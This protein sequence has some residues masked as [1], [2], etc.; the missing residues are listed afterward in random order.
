MWKQ[1]I[2]M[3]E[4]IK[5][6]KFTSYFPTP[7]KYL[8]SGKLSFAIEKERERFNKLQIASQIFL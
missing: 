5:I 4:W 8:Y 7:I 1:N 6:L 3:F 2:T